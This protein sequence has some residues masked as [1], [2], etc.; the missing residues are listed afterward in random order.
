M[1]TSPIS[2]EFLLNYIPP[3]SGPNLNSAKGCRAGATLRH[4]VLKKG[5][6]NIIFEKTKLLSFCLAE[7]FQTCFVRESRSH[8]ITPPERMVAGVYKEQ[9]PKPRQSDKWQH[10]C[11]HSSPGPRDLEIT[12]R[13]GGYAFWVSWIV[14]RARLL[15]GMTRFVYISIGES[16]QPESPRNSHIHASCKSASWPLPASGHI[17]VLEVTSSYAK[18]YKD[19]QRLDFRTSRMVWI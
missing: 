9:P 2:L 18:I 1:I 8:L 6:K 16:L 13:C 5:T 14:E 3:L 11:V 15:A 17:D 4:K 19:M 7:F 10:N 12:T